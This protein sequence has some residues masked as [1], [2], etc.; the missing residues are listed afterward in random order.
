MPPTLA[1]VPAQPAGEEV[2]EPRRDRRAKV[3]FSSAFTARDQRGTIHLTIQQDGELWVGD[4]TLETIQIE[5][6]GDT[7]VFKA[8]Q[9]STASVRRVLSLGRA[10]R[11]SRALSK[12]V[13]DQLRK[14]IQT[15]REQETAADAA[16]IKQ[17]FRRKE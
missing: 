12:E 17:R 6:E 8:A 15:V 3:L 10:A 7:L 1:V 16:R 2:P 13:K 4:C 11:L 9:I 14:T 5:W